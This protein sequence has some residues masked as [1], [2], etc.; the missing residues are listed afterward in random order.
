MVELLH[1]REAAAR[2][3]AEELRGRI[4]QLAER[5]ARVEERMSRL[6]IAR[7]TVDEVL[8]EVGADV[9][10]AAVTGPPGPGHAPVIGA[11]AVPTWRAGLE[12]SM[13]PQACRDLLERRAAAAGGADRRGGGAQHGQGEGRDSAVEAEAAGGCRFLARAAY[14]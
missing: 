11:L 3:E 10:V 8:G 14:S 12:A 13:L 5:L 2:A 9:S 7:E 6:V 4:A 1:R